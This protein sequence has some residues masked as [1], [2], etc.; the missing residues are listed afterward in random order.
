MIAKK[1]IQKYNLKPSSY[2]EE[3]P[4]KKEFQDSAMAKEINNIGFARNSAIK[5]K[6][7]SHIPDRWYGFDL[8][9]PVPVV[10]YDAIDEFLDYAKEQCPD[11]EIYQIKLKM[12]GLRMYI[13]RVTEE[14]Q[15]ESLILASSLFDEFLIY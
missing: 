3:S 6:W 7:A 5:E 13:G 4:Y 11:F 12:G 9:Y 14:I 2:F 15:S 1:I 10:W 8:G